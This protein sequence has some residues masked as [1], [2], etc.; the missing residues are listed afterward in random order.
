MYVQLLV[1]DT[2]TKWCEGDIAEPAD[3]KLLHE[4]K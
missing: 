3:L 4:S 1:N 2:A